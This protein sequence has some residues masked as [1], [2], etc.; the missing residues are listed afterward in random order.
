MDDRDLERLEGE[1][2]HEAEAVALLDDLRERLGA[3]SALLLEPVAELT[4]KGRT[5]LRAG[6]L[7]Y[8]RDH[9]ASDEPGIPCASRVRGG[10]AEFAYVEPDGR[11]VWTFAPL[12]DTSSN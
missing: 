1:Y 3:D 11:L 2:E 4:E 7:M 12:G 5:V 6:G 10:R 9:R 8:F